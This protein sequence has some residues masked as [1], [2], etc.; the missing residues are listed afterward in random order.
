[1]AVFGRFSPFTGECIQLK[2]YMEA[3]TNLWLGVKLAM[4][5]VAAAWRCL[6]F[7]VFLSTHAD[8]QRC[9]YIVYCLCVFVSLFVCTVTD[10]SAENKASGVK[11]CRAI[12]QRPRQG[13]SHFVNFAPRSPK[14]DELA[15]APLL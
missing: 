11:F 12:H 1:L 5:G 6:S 10:F 15:S 9:G 3:C 14:L 7:L 13:I 4:C 8:R 2:Y